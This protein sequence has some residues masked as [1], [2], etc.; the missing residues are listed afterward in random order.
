MATIAQRSMI[1]RTPERS[2]DDADPEISPRVRSS[3]GARRAQRS[4]RLEDATDCLCWCDL[5][6]Q[7]NTANGLNRIMGPFSGRRFETH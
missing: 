6:R 2:T 7:L 5:C 3:A 1:A 4:V